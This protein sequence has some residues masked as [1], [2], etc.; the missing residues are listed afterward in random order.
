M[1]IQVTHGP[2]RKNRRGKGPP[3]NN[4][5]T[6]PPNQTQTIDFAYR[7]PYGRELVL[8]VS[9]VSD[10]PHVTDAQKPPNGHAIV[11]RLHGVHYVVFLI[12]T[13]FEALKKHFS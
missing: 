12:G 5:G 4:G 6:Q 2:R 11:G 9:K 3:G 10:L 8:R 7:S 1:A 13:L